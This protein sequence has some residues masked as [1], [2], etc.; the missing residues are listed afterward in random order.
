MVSNMR[1]KRP[2]ERTP[3]TNMVR[4][5]KL[6][7]IASEDR[8]AVKQYFEFFR[9]TEIQF[10][11]LSTE[12]NNSSPR[13][14]MDRLDEYLNEYQIGDEDRLWYVGDTD[15]WTQPNHIQKLVEV[16]RLCKQKGIGFSLSNPCFDL[17]LLL[18]FAKFPNETNLTCEEI[19]KRIRIKAGRFDKT[20]VYNLPI[21]INRVATAI[22][23]SKANYPG[24]EI[25]AQLQTSVHLIIEDLIDR[26]I[27]SISE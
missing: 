13:R 4:D 15:H 9:S 20:K 23:R 17:W 11:V 24:E 18:H 14:I 3:V 2:L 27:I 21:D 16:R 10:R 26:G 6:I 12:D 7:V 22:K 19:G 25:P 8:Y 5:A 1:K